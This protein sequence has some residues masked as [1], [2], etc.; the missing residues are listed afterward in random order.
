MASDR[1]RPPHRSSCASSA[2][3]N[4]SDE[5]DPKPN[6]EADPSTPNST[7]PSGATQILTNQEEL[8]K[9]WRTAQNTVRACYL[10]YNEPQLSNQKDKHRRHMIGYPCKMDGTLISRQM[11]VTH[12]KPQPITPTSS[13]PPSNKARTGMLA[14]LGSAAAARG[15]DSLT[16]A[17]DMWL[18]GALV[19]KGYDPVNPLKWW[20][21]QKKSGNTYGGLAHMALDVLSCPTTSVD[22]ER[23]FSLGR[24]YVLSKRHRLAPQSI[25][26]GMTVAFYSKN[27]KIK[28][29]MLAK[30]KQGIKDKNKTK[31]K[32]KRK[33]IVLE[34]D[35]DE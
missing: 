9:A 21:Q 17:F 32:L 10:A 29:G 5:D 7:Q 13:A 1:D 15:G 33:V 16:D 8:A 22:V 23:A 25:S 14:G 3:G 27:K 11:W 12:Y 34:D 28:E 24:D 4:Q 19:L 31:K 30:W 20:I 18:A 2:L 6:T 35:D 26:R